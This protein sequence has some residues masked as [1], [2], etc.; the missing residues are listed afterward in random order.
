MGNT[1]REIV[2]Y[3]VHRA[4]EGDK[5]A[6]S[7][8]VRLM[9]KDIVALTYRMT[10]DRD[11]SSDL[12]QETFISAWKSLRSFRNEAKFE[13]WL[14]RIAANNALNYLK[15]RTR[16][17]VT[18]IDSLE[19]EALASGSSPRNPEQLLQAKEIQKGVLKFMAE[20]P[21]QQRL[22]FDLRFY[23]ELTFEEIAEITG[24]AVG[25]V[26]THYRKAIIKLRTF[27][28]RKGWRR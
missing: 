9:M 20:L 2:E 7:R 16:R 8:L 5:E 10:Q 1:D 17:P 14:Y 23:K 19:T 6:F 13:N 24:K 22:V 27:A 4:K 11:S 21:D 15:Q 12:A 18:S 26:K 3:L 28:E 25:T